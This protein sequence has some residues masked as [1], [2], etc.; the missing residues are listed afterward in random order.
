MELEGYSIPLSLTMVSGRSRWAMMASNS[1]AA[2]RP[3]SEVSATKARHSHVQ[4]S[5]TVRNR[6][7]S[8]NWSDTKSRLQR[9]F[10]ARGTSKGRR[11]PMGR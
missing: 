3:D 2:R 10:S 7:S 8:V 5:I 1:R 9:G 11:V 6:R 4:L